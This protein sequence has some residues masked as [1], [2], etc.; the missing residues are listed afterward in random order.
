MA[1]K[2]YL[3]CHLAENTAAARARR[4]RPLKPG[5]VLLPMLVAMG[6]MLVCIRPRLAAQTA[7][8]SSKA[9]SASAGNVQNG[10][11][12]YTS[13]GCYECHGRAAHGGTGPRIGP[14]ALPFSAFVAYVRH[15]GGTMPPYTAKVASDQDLADIYA[16][17]TSLPGSP[18]A[19]DVPLLSR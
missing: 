1:V 19:K 12:L 15:P 10:K 16:Y 14:D 7:A 18:K 2:K 5:G 4:A 8:Q 17:V 3:E 11:K 13:Y 6:M 9:D